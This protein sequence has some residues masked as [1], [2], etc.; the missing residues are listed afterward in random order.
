M[1]CNLYVCKGD[2]PQLRDLVIG[3]GVVAPLL[4]FVREDVPLTFLR[5]V[6][7]VIVNLCR[8]KEPPPSND[9]IGKLLPALRALIQHNDTNVRTN[10]I[11]QLLG[12]CIINVS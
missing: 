3:L 7:W 6:T 12:Y 5:N 9:T 4:S 10:S 8:N 1:Y 11:L 2:G